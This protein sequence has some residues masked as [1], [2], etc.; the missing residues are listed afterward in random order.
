MSGVRVPRRPCGSAD[1]S[2]GFGV[3]SV[4]VSEATTV[5]AR[6]RYALAFGGLLSASLASGSIAPLAAQRGAENAPRILVPTLHARPASLGAEAGDAIR[7]R[8]QREFTQRTLW[9]IGK[10]DIVNFLVASG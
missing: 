2:R 1:Q 6:H 8:F 10:N 3:R 5:K 4:N 9:V 7:E